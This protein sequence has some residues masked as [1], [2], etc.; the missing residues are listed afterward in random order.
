MADFVGPGGTKTYFFYLVEF[1]VKRGFV[2]HSYLPDLGAL[3]INE[4]EDL[5]GNGVVFNAFPGY[6]P[7]KKGILSRM[8]FSELLRY[9][10]LRSLKD[11]Y[12]RVLVSS[13]R[14]F[15]FI[16]GA[17][18]WGKRFC[19]FLFTYPQ[20][21]SSLLSKLIRPFRQVYFSGLARK[22]FSFITPTYASK[23]IILDQKG[24]GEKN[25]SVTV[26]SNP[27]M[28]GLCK[29]IETDSKLVVTIGHVEK[30][31]NPDFWL[32]V[33]KEVVDIENNVVFIWGGT[34]SMEE[35]IKS[36]ISE[37]HRNQIIMPGYVEDLD[38]LLNKTAVY[39]QPS[40][41][42]SQG[43]SVVEAMGHSVPCV[44]SNVGGLP[45]VVE[46]GM[47]GYVIELDIKIAANR[48]LSILRNKDIS[49][50]MSH[51]A[52]LR[53]KKEY[54]LE[55]WEKRLDQVLFTTG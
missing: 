23:R 35:K 37:E 8:G 5:E 31:K 2:V 32:Q 40:L 48:I 36:Q 18:K 9:F 17:H 26:I 6:L 7:K 28:I 27:A 52:L 16:S 53:Y 15:E 24:L 47:S 34:G 41:V 21:T 25:L 55:I 29:K 13:G 12:Y 45:E 19:F 39:F 11:D 49:E 50:K 4:R 51:E 10:F 30:W 42:E 33:A 38:Q 1:L 43:I 46:D 22:G 20:G 54:T 3:T 44:V 14:S